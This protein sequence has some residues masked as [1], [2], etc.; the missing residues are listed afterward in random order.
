MYIF[1]WGGVNLLTNSKKK[2]VFEI[3]NCKIESNCILKYLNAKIIPMYLY[4]SPGCHLFYIKKL[5]ANDPK[6][7]TI[8]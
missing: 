8:L 6:T 7:I 2:N 1:L 4:L 3:L 5:W